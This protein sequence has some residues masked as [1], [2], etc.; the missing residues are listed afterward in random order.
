MGSV[1]YF[2]YPVCSVFFTILL[3]LWTVWSSPCGFLYVHVHK[4]SHACGLCSRVGFTTVT[5]WGAQGLA[6][7]HT[8]T[9]TVVS[10]MSFL[11]S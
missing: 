2:V 3:S 4:S 8:E 5:M 6:V 9:E 1:I 7:G 11:C 10:L